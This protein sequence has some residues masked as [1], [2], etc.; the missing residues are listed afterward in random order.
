MRADLGV[1]LAGLWFR[2]WVS[3]AVLVVAALVVGAAATGPLFLRA[4]GESVLRDTLSTAATSG[5]GVADTSTGPLSDDPVGRLRSGEQT[6]LDDRP[7]LDRLLGPAVVSLRTTVQA[8]A[9]GATPENVALVWRD[10]VCGH[11]R[12]T[13]GA[14][15][16]QPGTVVASTAT[17]AVEGWQVGRPLRVGTRTVVLAGT[18]VPLDPT[19]DYWAGRSYFAALAGGAKDATGLDALFAAQDTFTQQGPGTATVA[20]SDRQLVV[21]RVRVADLPGLEREVDTWA[22]DM[23]DPVVG[24]TALPVVLLDA[25][26]VVAGLRLPITVVEVQLLVLCWL[27]LFLVVANAAEARGPEVALAKLRGVGTGATVAFGLLDTLLL[28]VLAVPLGFGLAWAWTLGLTRAQLAPGVPVVLTPGAFLAAA[29]AGAGAA[30]AAALATVRTLRR[31]VVEQWRRATRRVRARSWV[32]DA[33]V[34]VVALVGLAALLRPRSSLS[35][36]PGPLALVAPGLVVLVAALVGSRLLPGLCRALYGPTRRHGRVASLLA[37][38]Q[39][40]RRPGTLRLAL[41]LTVAFGLVAFGVDA[42]V[43]ARDNAHDRAWTEVGAAEVLTVSTTPGDDLGD[44]VDRIDPGGTQV[45]A[46]STATDFTR[47]PPMLLAGVQPDRFAHVAYWRPDLGPAPLAALTD[48]LRS[49]SAAPVL[50]SGDRV[51]VVVDVPTMSGGPAPLLVADVVQP[52]ALNGVSPVVLGTVG[53]GRRTLEVDL[54]CVGKTC[55]LAGVELRRSGTGLYAYRGSVRMERLEV[56]GPDGWRDLGAGLT[57]A[58]GWRGTTDGARTVTSGPQGTVL[59]VDAAATDS[60]TWQVADHPAVLPALVSAGVTDE[61][62][63]STTGFGDLDLPLAPAATLAA[64]PGAGSRGVLVDRTDARRASEGSLLRDAE[65]MWLA[66]GAVVW[67]PQQLEAAGVTVLATS[68]AS[69]MA[70][71]YA[72]QGP[73]LAL[74][75]YLAGAGLAALLA[76]AGAVL[77]LHLNGRR[78]TYELAAMAA[79]GLRRRTLLASLHLEQALLVLFGLVVGTAAG[80][81]AAVLALPSIPEFVDVPTA[82]PLRYDVHLGPVLLS[83]LAATLVLAVAVGLSSARLVRSARVDQLREAPA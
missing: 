64:V 40:G 31:P 28:V 19:G 41:L 18:Y 72:R 81:G 15:P 59:T 24:D 4:A 26:D 48:R 30:V 67:A 75:L 49:R 46:V 42:W 9:P 12:I 71:V 3:V 5:R 47:L 36:A 54:P 50:M 39:L 43:T 68:S 74:L 63:S 7:T 56:R 79:L 52:S 77:S 35:P 14:C 57:T 29:G 60:P 16:D 32:V 37:V 20:T 70:T 38:R 83:V 27:V 34:A 76:G 66:P 44:V 6:K 25:G 53:P 69:D 2:R 62:R 61:R 65:T 22:T 78:R 58:D 51:R 33:A 13:A 1:V 45:A 55:R 80:I 82:P 21:D 8:G 10:G 23:D 73:A 11:L 17:A